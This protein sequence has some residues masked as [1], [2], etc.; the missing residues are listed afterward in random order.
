MRSR[1]YIWWW[2]LPSAILFLGIILIPFI[3]ALTYSFRSLSFTTSTATGQ[4]IGVENYRRLVFD[5]DFYNSFKVT[6]LYM[7]PAIILQGLLGFG[8]GAANCWRSSASA[9]LD[10][11]HAF[12]H[13]VNTG[14]D[15]LN[16]G[17]D[18]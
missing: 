5:Q 4:Y 14:G 12:T 18:A 3:T 17:F 1:R 9:H 16:W 8:D 6:F 13:P 7:V 11:D 10:T 2:V 15:W